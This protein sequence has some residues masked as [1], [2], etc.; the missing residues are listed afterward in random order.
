MRRTVPRRLAVLTV[1]SAAAASLAGAQD[2][3]LPSTS[4]RVAPGVS[5]WSFGTP[6]GQT[7]GALESVRQTSVSFGWRA[8]VADR[9]DIDLSG[10]YASS[11][12]SFEQ[13]GSARSLKLSGPTDLKLRLSTSIGRDRVLITAG[14]NLPT[15]TTGLDDAQTAVLQ[16]IS[17]PGMQLPVPAHGLGAGGTFGLAF[18]QEAGAWA[19]ALGGSVEKRNEYTAVDIALAQGRSLTKV[20]PGVVTH[21]TAGADRAIGE[22]RFSLLLVGDLYG[23]DEVQ[24]GGDGDG[25]ASRYTLG[26]QLTV[27]SVLDI[28]RAGWRQA[29]ARVSVRHR[30]AFTDGAG[31]TVEG[32]SGQYFEGSLFGVRGGVTGR[33]LVLG[34]DARY[35]TGFEFSDALV[36]AAATGAGLTVGLEW[37][38]ARVFRLA[39]RG[40]VGSFDTG[41]TKSNAT[42][43]SLLGAFGGRRTP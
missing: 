38:D 40:Q 32:S 8:T 5:M 41:T 11:T 17:A 19:L 10:A 21:V 23:E 4:W 12:A 15:G 26:P 24:L 36:A 3:L 7:V 6:I 43:V 9:L 28:A 2:A 42:G 22:H 25:T 1:A 13:S 35:H 34:L 33:G 18:A 16:V 39:L 14:A 29:N 27:L 30:S 20:T 37:G 31:A